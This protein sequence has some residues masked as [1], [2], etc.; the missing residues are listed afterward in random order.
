MGGRTRLPSPS[1]VAASVNDVEVDSWD[2]HWQIVK[3]DRQL[4]RVAAMD[5][6]KGVT[7]KIYQKNPSFA[8]SFLLQNSGNFWTNLP[9]LIYIML[10]KNFNLHRKNAANY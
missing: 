3:E 7:R 2:F 9:F 1:R 5:V 4:H 6:R 8:R 10:K